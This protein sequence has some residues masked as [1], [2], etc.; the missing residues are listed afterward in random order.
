MITELMA[1]P[2]AAG[3]ASA[4]P[5]CGSARTVWVRAGR[6]DNLLCKTCGA[7]WRP[8]TADGR[9]VRADPRACAG[10]GLRAVCA[11]AAGG[12]SAAA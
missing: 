9:A 11:A 7:C 2:A 3:T 6:L 8:G 1:P 12:F 4:C 5:G 10:C